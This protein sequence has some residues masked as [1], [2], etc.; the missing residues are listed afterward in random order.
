MDKARDLIIRKMLADND[1]GSILF[2]RSDELV[3][4]SGYYPLWGIS[5][6]LYPSIGTP[7]IYIPELEPKDEL[8]TGFTIKTFPWG[9]M[10]CSNP[11][12]VLFD[13][14]NKDLEILGIIDLPITFSQNNGQ[15]SPSQISAEFPPFPQNFQQ[16][17]S[18]VG[19]GGY[20]DLSNQINELYQIKT[21]IEIEK[22]RL[23]NQVAAIGINTFYE[24]LVAWKSEVEVACAVES[25]VQ[26]QTGKGKIKF[27][28]AWPYIMS[29]IN[30]ADG[31]SFPRTTAKVLQ[32]GDLV[33]IEM[34]VCVNGYWCDITRTGS[35]GKTSDKLEEV[36]NIVKHAQNLA[37]AAIKPGVTGDFI[38]NI[39]RSNIRDNGYEKYYQHA[40]GHHV[41]FRYHDPGQGLSSGSE[42]IIQQ[43][44]VLTVEPGIYGHEFGGG[45]R[46]E[47][48]ILVTKD[49]V[50]VLSTYSVELDGK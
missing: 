30:S 19:Q 47:E 46:I 25:A 24:N 21:P 14:I 36:Y 37:L 23:A 11:W 26:L 43:G 45:C 34:A 41:G 27:A 33:M 38:D 35:V 2:W 20:K 5:V 49:G 50:E 31:G 40:L 12:R 39:I 15:S 18:Q 42:L 44:M 7:I 1:V 28:K 13:T 17:S 3:L 29:G 9:N 16:N 10:Q 4:C 6:C 48:N 32:K 8:P 22:I